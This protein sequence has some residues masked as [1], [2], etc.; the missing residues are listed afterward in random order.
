MGKHEDL[1]NRHEGLSNTYEK[2]VVKSKKIVKKYEHLV[3]QLK[4]KIECPVCL[5]VP[6][7]APIP[8]CPNGHIIC[9]KC[10]RD[11]CPTCRVRMGQGRST[12][13]VTVIEN[14]D[15]QCENEGCQEVIP[16]G[17]LASHGKHCIH[18]LVTCPDLDCDDMVSL[19]SLSSHMVSCCCLGGN[20]IGV[21]KRPHVFIKSVTTEVERKTWKLSA[22]RFSKRIFMLKV[23]RHEING[24]WKWFFLVQMDGS[25]E[26]TSGYGVT[27][28]VHRTEDGREGKYSQRYSGDVCPIDVA[29]LE[30]AEEKGLCL[31]L[32]DG[33]MEKLFPKDSGSRKK[34]SVSVELFESDLA[35]T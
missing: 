5:T 9:T 30:R 35:M 13:A 19:S 33:A 11:E 8:I 23:A 26:E 34:F 22:M 27:I 2:L 21:Y 14:L 7:K 15:H 16:F 3:Q 12:L 4:D 20:K 17:E 32:T 1:S 28:I 10:V 29:T 25:E 31:S 18:R 24:N 6:Q